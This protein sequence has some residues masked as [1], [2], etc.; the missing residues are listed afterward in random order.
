[1]WSS[2][3]LNFQG[4]RFPVEVILVCIRWYAGYSLSNLNLGEMMKEREVSVDQSTVSRS[5]TRFLPLS[6]RGFRKNIY[7]NSNLEFSPRQIHSRLDEQEL[8]SFVN[9]NPM[10][11][12][13]CTIG[14]RHGSVKAPTIAC[15]PYF[16]W[17]ST[18]T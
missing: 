7:K 2:E 6:G 15:T 14:A 5:A 11:S 13:I 18:A 1:M 9:V 8:S 10:E 12:Q 16:C 17:R 4:I 3:M